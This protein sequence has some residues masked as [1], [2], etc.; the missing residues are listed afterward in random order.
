MS[1]PDEAVA[2]VPDGPRQFTPEELEQARAQLAAQEPP[3]DGPPVDSVGMGMDLVSKGAEAADVDAADMLAM[4]KSLS[5]KVARMEAEKRLEHAPDVVR[6]ATAIRDHLQ[7]KADANPALHSAAEHSW[8]PGIDL[9][10]KLVDEAGSAADAGKPSTALHN[11]LS[12]MEKWVN[13][14]ARRHPGLDHNYIVELI[15]EAA[16]A[17][18]KLAA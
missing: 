14:F 16:D 1:E 17:A 10:G 7:A 11:M 18:L 3:G 13:R 15:E 2:S 12:D 8:N 4:I 9:A 6:Y 5:A